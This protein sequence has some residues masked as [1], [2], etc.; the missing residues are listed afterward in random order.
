MR[1]IAFLYARPRR[2]ATRPSFV[3]VRHVRGG[4]SNFRG[5]ALLARFARLVLLVTL[6]SARGA[7]PAWLAVFMHARL[8]DRRWRL[9]SPGNGLPGEL[10]DRSDCLCIDGRHDRDRRAGAPGAAGAADAVYVVVG[11]MRARRN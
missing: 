9:T 8:F 1:V 10:L 2:G 6:A 5:G 7:L 11:M 4:T 3:E